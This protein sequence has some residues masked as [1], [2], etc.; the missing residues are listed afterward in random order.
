MK[1]IKATT[2]VAVTNSRHP[3]STPT[4]ANNLY[5]KVYSLK[6]AAGLSFEL[7]F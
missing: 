5:L 2:D 4:S 7:S 1:Q 6:T 3:S